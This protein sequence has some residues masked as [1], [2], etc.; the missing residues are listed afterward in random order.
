MIKEIKVTQLRIGMYVTLLDHGWFNHPFFNNSFAVRSQ[1]DIDK[2]ASMGIESI[3][4]DTR[5]GIDIAPP[6]VKTLADTET[7]EVAPRADETCPS[8]TKYLNDYN[9]A[10][11]HAKK[12]VKQT[13]HAV[14]QMM[15]DVR[16]G[17]AVDLTA[18]EHIVS[19]VVNSIKS[20]KYMLIGVMR[21]RT[22]DEYTFIHS[23]SVSAILASFA[24]FLG[25]SEQEVHEIT[26][27]GLLHDIGKST[28]PL[29]ILNKPGKLT[30]PEFVIMK[31]HVS[32]G[33]RIL[34]EQYQLSPIA[35]DVVSM[36]HERLD[37]SG[38]PRGLK[39]DQISL[40][41]QMSAI[42]DVY[43][44][45]SSVRAYKNAWEPSYVLQQM[46]QWSPD[47]FDEILVKKFIKM[48]GIYP[49]GSLVETKNG[50]IALVIHQN[51]Q[52]L[53]PVIKLIYDVNTRRYIAEQ[54]I[55]LS[56]SQEDEII[57]SV[58]PDR[59]H[60]DMSQFL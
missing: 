49:V 10:K 36:H 15:D 7:L 35:R 27:G 2:L 43:D 24:E 8:A 38:Y 28:T 58:D 37:G 23:V 59:Y 21:L 56:V 55:D 47:L 4:I 5:K 33:E 9:Y 11:K 26:I 31:D 25:F 42:C 30:D 6:S 45:L 57:G 14:H 54:A 50:Y 48:L 46:L 41:G 51:A 60:I 53:T 13:S 40:V 17:K 3:N 44:A 18:T 16:M 22:K 19:E 12:I 39:G 20:D 32:Q 29:E 1:E 52:L 34:N